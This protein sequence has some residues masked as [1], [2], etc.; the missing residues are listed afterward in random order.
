VSETRVDRLR[1]NLRGGIKSN[2]C[3]ITHSPHDQTTST[4][5]I[6]PRHHPLYPLVLR[7]LRQQASRRMRPRNGQWGLMV[8]LAMRKHRP[9]TALTRLLTTRDYRRSRSK[10]PRLSTRCTSQRCSI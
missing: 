6:L 5:F 7:S 10:R 3:C 8:R 1:L 9:E 4:A 2:A